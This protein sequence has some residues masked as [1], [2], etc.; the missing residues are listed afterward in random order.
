KS[1]LSTARETVARCKL[2]ADAYMTRC[3]ILSCTETLDSALRSCNSALYLL[4][5]AASVVKMKNEERSEGGATSADPFAASTTKATVAK[6]NQSDSHYANIFASNVAFKEAQWVLA[7]KIGECLQRISTLHL[8]KGSWQEARYYIKQCPTLGKRVN[9]SSIIYYG[10]IHLSDYHLHCGH[11]ESSQEE[12]R[13][14]FDIQKD[15]KFVAQDS[16]KLKMAMINY[17]LKQNHLVE[18]I[19]TVD[20]TNAILEGLK[21]DESII[22]LEKYANV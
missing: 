11:F 3:L 14:A 20:E 8:L 19:E 16:I 15:E 6:P 21:R 10:H 7:Q 13:H 12:L 17:E 9:S 4:F 2:L 1:V 5:R 22:S 18:A